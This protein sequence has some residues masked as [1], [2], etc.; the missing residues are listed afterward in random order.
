MLGRST[1]Y[2]FWFMVKKIQ[3]KVTYRS[4]RATS[5]LSTYLPISFLNCSIFV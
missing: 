1:A 3:F 4:S 5:F 2:N